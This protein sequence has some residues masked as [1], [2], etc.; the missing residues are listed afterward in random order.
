MPTFCLLRRRCFTPESIRLFSD[1]VGVAKRDNVIDLSLLEWCVREDL[2][3]RSNRYM[4]VLNPVKLL[5]VNYPED[6][7]ETMTAPLNPDKP[8][9]PSR[10]IPFSRSSILKGMILWRTPQKNISDC[11]PEARSD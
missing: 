10:K 8:D 6:L 2:N 9:G 11:N 7:V 5:I 3:K 1:K 4:A